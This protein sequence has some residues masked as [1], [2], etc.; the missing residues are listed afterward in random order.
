[1]SQICQAQG[2]RAF[3]FERDTFAFENETFWIYNYDENG[4]LS[5][6]PRQPKPTY[7]HRC[8]VLTRAARRF[9]LHARFEPGQRPADD[10]TC[11]RL[12]R[13]VNARPAY[14]SCPPD[15]Q[16]VI[17]GYSCLREFSQARE[18]ILKANCGSAWQ[19]YFLR[20]HWRMIFPLSREHQAVTAGRLQDTLARKVPAV[21]H[22]VKFPSLA[23]NHSI[24]VYS[25]AETPLGLQF[26][27]YDPNVPARPI[28][29]T[30]DSRER[31]FSFPRNH[32]WKGGPLNVIEICRNRWM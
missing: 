2:L 7:G 6:S 31:A 11:A 24:L 29:V 26:E 13:E 30:Y 23:V 20:S 25:V 5:V 3:E 10:L 12:V 28:C 19:S 27:G 4:K 16:I 8:F 15:L 1:M 32:Y 17:P 9:F 18:P 22:I 14:K 21:L